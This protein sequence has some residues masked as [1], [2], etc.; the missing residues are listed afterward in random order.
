MVLKRERLPPLL[1]LHLFLKFILHEATFTLSHTHCFYA[2]IYACILIEVGLYY[3]Y[4]FIQC[5]LE[6]FLGKGKSLL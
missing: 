2:C 5:V 1:A 6:I 4:S 3:M